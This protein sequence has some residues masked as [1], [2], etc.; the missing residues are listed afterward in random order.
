MAQIISTNRLALRELSVSDAENFYMLNSDPEVMRYTGDEPFE[1]IQSVWV[2]LEN[3]P[4]YRLNGYGRWAVQL[5]GSKQ[6][7]GWCGLKLN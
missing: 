5:K 2:F 7:V 6:F 3:Y 1:S 4:D